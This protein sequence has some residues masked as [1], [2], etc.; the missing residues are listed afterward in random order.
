MK[1]CGN[2][3]WQASQFSPKM[4]SIEFMNKTQGKKPHRE[5]FEWF[6]IRNVRDHNKVKLIEPGSRIREIGF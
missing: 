1:S 5:L 4:N 6:E 3:R 2:R